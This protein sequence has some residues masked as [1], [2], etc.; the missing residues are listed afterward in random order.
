MLE[1]LQEGAI[2]QEPLQAHLQHPCI[3]QRACTDEV[4]HKLRHCVVGEE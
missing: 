1:G 3:M 2:A 4:L